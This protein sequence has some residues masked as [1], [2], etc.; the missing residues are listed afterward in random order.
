[1]AGFKNTRVNDTGFLEIPA[2]TTAQR[3]ASPV[4]GMYR[5]NTT[6]GYNEY[7]D[8]TEWKPTI[9]L[10]QPLSC[11]FFENRYGSNIGTVNVYVVNLGGGTVGSSIHTASGDNGNANWLPVTTDSPVLSGDYRIAWHYVSGTSF[12]GD[13]AIDT[14]SI[15]GTNYNFDSNS[16][17]FLTTSGVNTSSSTTALANS[18][19]VPTTTGGVLGRWNRDS[20]TTPS[21]STGPSS[22]QSGSFYLYAETSNPNYSNV[23]MWLFSPVFAV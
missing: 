14:V 5:F 22:A 20:G 3:P 13:Y 7:F 8:G 6:E 1:M 16:D 4:K 2:G 15:M 11:S 18:V 9:V 21:G 10:G 17:G 19:A 12:R 23:N